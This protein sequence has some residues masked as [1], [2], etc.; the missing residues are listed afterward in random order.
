MSTEVLNS[1]NAEL[2]KDFINNGE[3]VDDEERAGYWIG[4][5]VEATKTYRSSSSA[6][7]KEIRDKCFN[8]AL[9]NGASIGDLAA[10]TDTS[11]GVSIRLAKQT[12]QLRVFQQEEIYDHEVAA[13]TLRIKRL[14]K[15]RD[16]TARREHRE[17]TRVWIDYDALVFHQRLRRKA[18][19]LL[20]KADQ[21]KLERSKTKWDEW[22]AYEFA[23]DYS[24]DQTIAE[25]LRYDAMAHEDEIVE[26]VVSITSPHQ[27]TPKPEF[28]VDEDEDKDPPY[29]E[30]DF[31]PD[32]RFGAGTYYKKRRS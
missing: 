6:I 32:P 13:E 5:T 25:N 19:K 31:L 10:K 4:K 30:E 26:E 23:P 24:L 9:C 15:A 20:T 17:L 29:R 7:N 12:S 11:M 21:A 18:G 16:E 22:V 1:I 2:I 28:T 8:R 27:T 14:I 3:Y